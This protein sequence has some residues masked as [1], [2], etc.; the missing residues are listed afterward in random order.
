MEKEYNQFLVKS[1]TRAIRILKKKF[2]LLLNLNFF[3]SF[4]TLTK[5]QKAPFVL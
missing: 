3:H 2:Q 4:G 1:K 5:T